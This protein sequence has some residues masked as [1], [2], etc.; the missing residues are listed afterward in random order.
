[1][2]ATEH[3]RARELAYLIERVGIDPEEAPLRLQDGDLWLVV[4]E[5]RFV[6]EGEAGI[7]EWEV[8][9]EFADALAD[10]F[11]ESTAI[12]DAT[13]QLL[14]DMRDRAQEALRRAR[15]RAEAGS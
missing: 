10:G 4:P 11:S 6:L 14:W 3:E 8:A 2:N 9:V 7:R 13:R 12:N 1:M 15:R 5:C